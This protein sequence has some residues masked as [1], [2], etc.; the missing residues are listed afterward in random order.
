MTPP[1][2]RLRN[3]P[4]SKAVKSLAVVKTAKPLALVALV[5]ASGCSSFRYEPVA[6]WARD[7][8]RLCAQDREPLFDDRAAPRSCPQRFSETTPAP[9]AGK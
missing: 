5:L 4:L 7:G 2:A 9:G 8:G 6:N 1:G 3:R